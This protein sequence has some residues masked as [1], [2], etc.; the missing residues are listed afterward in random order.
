MYMAPELANGKSYG[1]KADCWALGCVIYE[2]VTLKPAFIA[3]SMDGLM[4]RIRRGRYNKVFPAWC[5]P[6]LQQIIV[7]LLN[8]DPKSRPSCAG[9]LQRAF[10]QPYLTEDGAVAGLQEMADPTAVSRHPAPTLPHPHHALPTRLQAR[11]L[12]GA[13]G[14]LVRRCSP[15]SVTNRSQEAALARSF[16]AACPY[17]PAGAGRCHVCSCCAPPPSPA[18][19]WCWVH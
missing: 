3:Q 8:V 15:L 11:L 4:S 7:E 16:L 9:I 12:A 18:T 14:L 13:P 10:L 17:S 5:G 2:M 19:K 6:D 1:Q